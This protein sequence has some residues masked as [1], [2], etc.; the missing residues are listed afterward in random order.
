MVSDKILQKQG[1][2]CKLY[3]G[4]ISFGS[5]KIQNKQDLASKN[6]DSIGSYNLGKISF[7]SNKIQNK[8]DLAKTGSILQV[9]FRQDFI[10]K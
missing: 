1:Q 2:S 4:K 8:Q 10:W 5:N 7:G 9:I 6:R 3:L